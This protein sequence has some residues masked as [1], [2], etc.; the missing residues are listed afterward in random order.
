MST[1][2][3]ANAAA[4][5][6]ANKTIQVLN[7]ASSMLIGNDNSQG[8][9]TGVPTISGSG[10]NSNTSLIGEV[11]HTLTVGQV[12]PHTHNLQRNDLDGEREPYP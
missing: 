1:G 7:L 5:F 3:G 4:D 9:L 2:R 6:A 11:L 8:I 10:V 12:P